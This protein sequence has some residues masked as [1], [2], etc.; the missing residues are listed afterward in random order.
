MNVDGRH[1]RPLLLN[2]DAPHVALHPALHARV[3]AELGQLDL[4]RGAGEIEHQLARAAAGKARCTSDEVFVACSRGELLALLLAAHGRPRARDGLATVLTVTPS[5]PEFRD[6]PRARGLRVVEVP[7]DQRWDL[8]VASLLRACEMA[9]PSLV[10][11]ASPNDPTSNRFDPARVEE[12]VRNAPEALVLIDE[13]LAAYADGDHEQ[14]FRTYPN[15]ALLRT[16]CTLLFPGEPVCWLLARPELVASLR[17]L[18]GGSGVGA[19]AARLAT[20]C[21]ND[22]SAEAHEL[23]EQVRAERAR[24]TERLEAIPGVTVTPSAAPFLWL[25]VGSAEAD[26]AATLKD[27]GVLVRGYYERGGRLAHQL[28]VT[29]ADPA[30]NDEF[31]AKLRQSI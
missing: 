1:Q 20:L 18:K 5:V 2:G 25:S 17:T 30:T 19:V 4:Q 15:V 11:L 16:T 13:S 26:V 6:L 9:A 31:L 7:L 8:H 24:V 10:L 14:L 27:K 21:L 29:V 28:R 22:L 23:R 3:L 12:F